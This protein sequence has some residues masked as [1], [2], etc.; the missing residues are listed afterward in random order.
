MFETNI[1][2]QSP[3]PTNRHQHHCHTDQSGIKI[4]IPTVKLKIPG[5]EFLKSESRT[6]VTF[7]L[8][9]LTLAIYKWQR[10]G[11]KILKTL[12]IFHN[13]FMV[14]YLL[15]P[16]RCHWWIAKVKNYNLN[17]SSGFGFQ[18]FFSRNFQFLRRYPS[19]NP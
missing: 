10:L 15:S 4:R 19:P 2:I 1:G 3:T 16:N 13:F 9:F 8:Y 18:K 5:K 11:L 6:S 17:R 7:K 14:A 12:Y